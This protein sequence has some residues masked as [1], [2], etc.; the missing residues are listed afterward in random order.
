MI[1][2]STIL[3]MFVSLVLQTVSLN[4]ALST[5]YPYRA[6]GTFKYRQ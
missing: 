6:S 2:L 4:G 3:L 1:L 5:R